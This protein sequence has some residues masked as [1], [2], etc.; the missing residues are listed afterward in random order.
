MPA[1]RVGT[2]PKVVSI[3]VKDAAGKPVENATVAT[4][5]NFGSGQVAPSEHGAVGTTGAGGTATLKVAAT[6]P[7]GLIAFDAKRENA[8]R[9]WFDPKGPGTLSITLAPVVR[10]FAEVRIKD[11]NGAFPPGSLNFTMV[12]D[13]TG[14][15]GKKATSFAGWAQMAERTLLVLPAGDYAFFM[16]SPDTTSYS[17]K[18]TLKLKPGERRTLDPIEVE[19]TLLT[20]SYGKPALPIKVTDARGIAKPFN[21][22]DYKG[23]WVVLEFWGFW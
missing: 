10:V 2:E 12:G 17:T 23:K 22:A 8:G 20:K 7:M 21:L 11:W 3:K 4:G 15:D 13:E 14:V 1:T 6:R 5:W 9:V 19:M 18:A 16:F